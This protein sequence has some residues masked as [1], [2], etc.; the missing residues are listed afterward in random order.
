MPG[1]MFGANKPTGETREARR[2]ARRDAVR[3]VEDGLPVEQLPPARA[4][5]TISSCPTSRSISSRRRTPITRTASR[6]AGRNPTAAASST[7]ASSASSSAR[8]A[9][10]VSEAEAG[11]YIFGY[12]CVNDVTAVDLLKKNPTFDQWV[13]RQELRH[14]R[15]VRPGDRDR[16]RPDEARRSAPCSTARSGRTT[17]SP[18][19]S[20]RRTSWWPRSRA[21]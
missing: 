20:S 12:T 1:D 8:N 3:P 9:A 13:A 17:R 19:C 6:S 5:R 10:N 11:D 14:V 2:R 18:T 15:R 4:P 16:P 7:R 21:T